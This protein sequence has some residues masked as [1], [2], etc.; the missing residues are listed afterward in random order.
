MLSRTTTI[1]ALALAL[2]AAGCAS[3]GTSPEMMKWAEA[4]N[5]RQAKEVREA[6]QKE[7]DAMRQQDIEIE[8]AEIQRKQEWLDFINP[9]HL[10]K[11]LKPISHQLIEA[12]NIHGTVLFYEVHSSAIDQD[13]LATEQWIVWQNPDL[14]GEFAKIDID[15]KLDSGNV[16]HTN[17]KFKQDLTNSELLAYWEKHKEVCAKPQEPVAIVESSHETPDY[18][19]TQNYSNY[20]ST[21][22]SAQGRQSATFWDKHGD[23]IVELALEMAIYYYQHKDSK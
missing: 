7:V 19:P 3:S 16:V 11:V 23:D 2:L 17:L 13:V 22:G 8:K 10:T 18:Q 6:R 1:T 21:T 9:A 20:Q 12:S 4:E 14:S 5:A 15:L